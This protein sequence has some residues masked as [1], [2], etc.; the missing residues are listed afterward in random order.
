VVVTEQAPLSFGGLLRQLRAG[1]GLTQEELAEAAG[2]SPRAVSALERGVNRTARKDTAELLAGALGLDGPARESFVA[3]ARGKVPAE[4][5]LA[6]RNGRTPGTDQKITRSVRDCPYR[7]LL[8]FGESD[9]EV[10][11]GRERLAAGLAAKLAA[12][13]A[14]GGLVV[15]TG[16]SGSGKSSL[17]RAGLLP[18]LARGEQLPESDR[19]PRIVMT[20]TK[21]PLTELAARLA[22]LGGPDALAVREGL[23]GHPDQAHLAIRSA[24]LAAAARRDEAVAASGDAS[25]RLVLIVD[26]F[27]QVFTLNPD[28]AG[29]A[30]RQA[31]ITALCS[32]AATP[33]GPGQEP[34]ALVVLAVRGDFSDRCAAVPELVGPLQDGHFV[35]GPMTESELRVAITGPAEAAGLQIDRVLT[36]A[37]LGD[38]RVAGADRSAGVLPLLSQAMALTWE[39]REGDRLTSRG[40]AQAGGVSRAVQTAADRAYGALPAGQQAIARDVLRSMTVASRDGGLARRPVTR[41]DL[42][43][44]LPD[45]ARADIDAVLDAFAAERLVVLDEGIAQLSHDVLLRAWP[46]LHE[47]L[48]EDR[49]SWVLYGQLAE[50][51]AAW[52][53]NNAD[54]SFL[55]RG[56]QLA[57]VEQGATTWAANPARYPV[58]SGTERSFLRASQRFA[59]RSSR[60]RR[61]LAVSLILLLAASLAG[62]AAAVLA[63]RK[64]DQQR[65]TAISSQLA[66]RSEALDIVDPVLAA[67]LARAAWQIAPTSQARDSMLDAFAQ[68]DRAVLETDP[69]GFGLKLPPNLKIPVSFVLEFTPDGKTLAVLW[70]GSYVQLWNVATR[71]QAGPPI[72][73]TINTSGV[74]AMAFSPDGRLL[75][76]SGSGIVSLWNVATR[77]PVG[78]PINGVSNP[79]RGGMVSRLAFSPDGRLL[80]TSST[81]GWVR[82]WNV[83][84]RHQVGPPIHIPGV[85]LHTGEVAFSPKGTL[86]ATA[87]GDGTVRL[88]NVATHDQVGPPINVASVPVGVVRVAFSPDGR[89]LVTESGHG[90]VQL[91]DVATHHPAG[92]PI[93]VISEGGG[94]GLVSFSPDGMFLATAGRDGIQLWNVATSEQA[95]PS[96]KVS[97]E[98]VNAMAFRPDGKVLAALGGDG[99]VRLLDAA[100]YQQIGQGIDVGAAGA[101]GEALS[102]DGSLVA[103]AGRDRLIRLQ[104]ITTQHQVSVQLPSQFNEASSN[105]PVEGESHMNMV[106]ASQHEILAV[107]AQNGLMVL[108]VSTR[109]PIFYRTGDCGYSTVALSSDGNILAF[110]QFD[111]YTCNGWNK[112]LLWDLAAGRMITSI[113][114]YGTD[115]VEVALSADGRI[116][117]T[118]DPSGLVRLWK[119]A[120]GRQIGR[121]IPVGTLSGLT[122]S[123]DGSLLAMAG[124]DGTV[125][126]WDVATRQQIG[127]SMDAS[128]ARGVNAVAFTP[129]GSLLATAG[130]DGTVR[131][132]D[133]ATQQQV[134]PSIEASN[135]GGVNA[136]TFSP[137]ATLLTTLGPDHAVRLWDVAFPSRLPNA[138]C[139]IAGHSLTPSEWKAYIPSEP[140]QRLCS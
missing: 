105:Y 119:V 45:T 18:I 17:L 93:S 20:P 63:A 104:N 50:D 122:F 78:P 6:A 113:N 11:Y 98:G 14:G 4:D 66:A 64:A 91:W 67:Q 79:A 121:A 24:V 5:V 134:G 2:L 106:F 28:L 29:E 30:T 130:G 1:A 36:D 138:M 8:P 80:A 102:A 42:Y 107:Q 72:N 139:S 71:R 60:L 103:A 61:V 129:D 32:A 133:V 41:H 52:R 68:P 13:A 125:L 25:A 48:E 44:R 94:P 137:D 12:R 31:F 97:A 115:V 85:A 86:L 27:E 56:A 120:T 127:L 112:V 89:L 69:G 53:G 100:E 116:L 26:Q 62:G 123:P 136:L 47:W 126:L 92:P 23:A 76:T 43:T 83:A 55:Y 75:A 38:L 114:T 108:D 87:G 10:F 34:A 3:A 16:A 128:T 132:W 96:M 19:W 54:S 9:A 57:A 37:I 40:Y 81:D 70:D 7:G 77:H 46:R 59:A 39:H 65:N 110:D 109:K 101:E 124:G 22:A 88:W 33:A 58:L 111:T 117:A 73:T 135:A 99:T 49:A 35:V 140:Y 84:T 90:T 82:L 21:D 118:V 131:L 95:G 15:V 74:D 51:A